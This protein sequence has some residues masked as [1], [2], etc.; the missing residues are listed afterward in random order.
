VLASPSPSPRVIFDCRVASARLNLL[1]PFRPLRAQF[2][3]L[4]LAFGLHAIVNRLARLRRQIRPTDPHIDD[5]D[6]ERL[7]FR[8]DFTPDVADDLLAIAR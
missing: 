2:L 6:A 7:G 3:R 8:G 4:A 5:L 1:R